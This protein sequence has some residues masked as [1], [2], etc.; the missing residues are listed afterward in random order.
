MDSFSISAKN[1]GALALSKSCP[2]CFWLKLRTSFKL[3]YQIFPGI[4]SSIDSYTKRVVNETLA[5]CGRL[6]E[7]LG[8]LGAVTE[9]LPTP[10]YRK[11]NTLIPEY[12]IQLTGALDA[13]FRLD[14]RTLLVA[15]Y[16]T[17][18]FTGA[19]DEL[20]PMYLVQLNGYALIAENLGLGKVSRLSLIYFQ[21]ETED[22]HVSDPKN[23]RDLGF[24]M[25]FSAHVLD[26]EL[27][28]LKWLD[29]YLKTARELSDMPRAPQPLEGCQDC[30]KLSVLID[31]LGEG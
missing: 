11:F 15:D 31:T 22:K 26:L 1:L 30:L 14:D 6:P 17:A 24:A 28:R 4:F 13:L 12:D 3:P 9:S 18:K 29:P 2:R 20:L 21:P 19:Q 8:Q 10:G 16:K 27:D 25:G 7:W 5:E 23:R